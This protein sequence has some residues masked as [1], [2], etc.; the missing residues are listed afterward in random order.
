M[1]WLGW[2]VGW[3]GWLGWAWLGWPCLA[4]WLAGLA[5]AGWGWLGLVG[6][7]WAGWA[8]WLYPT[9]WPNGFHRICSFCSLVL[10]GAGWLAQ[11]G[12]PAPRQSGWMADWLL[13]FLGL[14]AHAIG[15]ADWLLGFSGNY[16]CQLDCMFDI[17]KLDYEL[18]VNW[19]AIY[20]IWTLSNILYLILDFVRSRIVLFTEP[21]DHD[22]DDDYSRRRNFNYN[23]EIGL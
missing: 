12:W 5:G 6:A 3:A 18:R 21:R 17:Y 1:A 14:A 8:G 15:L 22:Y 19:I 11:S 10:A 7:G 9:T 2:P 23:L 20:W 4:G 13:G 16:S